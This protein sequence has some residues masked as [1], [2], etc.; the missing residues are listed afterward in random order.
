MQNIDSP[1]IIFVGG[2][3]LS[4]GLN[5]QMIK[6]S[7]NINPINTGIH[8]AIGLIYMM[9]NSLEYIKEGDI[10]ILVPEY[11]QF[12]GDIAFGNSGEELT[13]TIFDVNL[14]KFK[15]LKFKQI[16]NVLKA[17]PKYSI[18]KFKT[19][20]YYNVVENVIY[21]VNSFNSYG[22]VYKHWG[23]KKEYFEPSENLGTDFNYSVLK[24]VVDYKIEIE[25]KNAPLFIA[26]PGYQDT[27]FKNST[28]SIN[29]IETEFKKN[30]FKILGNPGRYM[31]P[32]SLMFN[33]PYHLTKNGVDYRTHLFITDL[34]E[35]LKYK[36]PS[37]KYMEREPQ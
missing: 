23:M 3:N 17:L 20:E 9:T 33:T 32:D 12:Y 10:V 5:S 36:L 7:L 8:A 6:D 37:M 22:D 35:G 21:S 26:Y 19:R 4:F 34:K 11:Q 1:R 24:E 27:S 28:E 2:S 31:F 18:S 25:K 16:I 30:G 13:R 15:N 29:Q 14:S